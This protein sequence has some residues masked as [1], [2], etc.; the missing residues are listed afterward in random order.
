MLNVIF[1]APSIKRADAASAVNPGCRLLGATRIATIAIALGIIHS[2][3]AAQS[4]TFKT[5]YHDI[6]K[7]PDAIWV[8]KDIDPSPKGV[9]TIYEYRLAT[10]QGEWLISQ[11]WNADCAAATCPT[12]LV[13]IEP[14]GQRTILV[15]DMMHQVIPPDDPRFAAMATSGDQLAFAEHP[16]AL[17]DDGKTFVNGDYKYQIEGSKP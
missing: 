4:F 16:F 3:A 10:P 14:G 1:S 9:V 8:G 17:A 12:R 2:A 15:D 13:Q 7:D 11:I 6:K 5:S